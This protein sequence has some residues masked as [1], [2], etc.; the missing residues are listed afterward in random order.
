MSDGIRRVVALS[1]LILGSGLLWATGRSTNDEDVAKNDQDAALA[2]ARERA[3]ANDPRLKGAYRYD[4]G[5]WVY[6]HLEGDPATIGFQHGF[7]LAPEIEDAF[8]AVSAGMTHPSKR[9]WAFFR[10]AAREMLW[11]KIDDE[12]K[13]ELQGIAIVGTAIDKHLIGNQRAKILGEVD[14]VA[15]WSAEAIKV[16]VESPTNLIE[17]LEARRLVTPEIKSRPYLV[18]ARVNLVRQVGPVVRQQTFGILP[19]ELCERRNALAAQFS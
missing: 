14:R 9:D 3:A 2:F 19:V 1:V 12:Y 17:I 10:Q 4:K 16:H 18:S 11:P 6:V 13:E 15:H 8:P 7:L 5:G